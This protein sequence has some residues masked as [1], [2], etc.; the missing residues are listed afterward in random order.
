[1]SFLVLLYPIAEFLTTA[2]KEA[3]ENSSFFSMDL[4]V[5]DSHNILFFR[6][7]RSVEDKKEKN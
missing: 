2:D 4:R 5:E 1:M 7:L 3:W 6:S